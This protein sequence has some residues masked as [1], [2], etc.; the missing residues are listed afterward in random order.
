MNLQHIA[1]FSSGQQGGNPAGVVIG[2]QL[3]ETSVMQKVAAQ[4]GYSETVFAAPVE[5]GWRVRYFAPEVEVDFVAMPRLRWARLL[6]VMRGLDGLRS[7]SIMRASL[8]RV[9]YRTRSGARRSSLLRPAA[10]RSLPPCLP[11]HSRF[12]ASARLISMLVFRQ[13]SRMAAAIIWCWR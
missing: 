13:P 1:A 8:S 9:I 4:L 7:I 5:S 12:S 11:K 3:P 6:R 10:G 2:E